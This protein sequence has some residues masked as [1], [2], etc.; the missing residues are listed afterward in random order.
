MYIASSNKNSKVISKPFGNGYG[1]SKEPENGS[2]SFNGITATL[3]KLDNN[4]G[5]S[6]TF[7]KSGDTVI[8]KQYKDI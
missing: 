6:I 2:L 7:G 4:K 3:T 1:T 8:A 5:F